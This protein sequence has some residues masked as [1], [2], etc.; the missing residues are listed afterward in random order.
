MKI[1][2]FSDLVCP[3][4]YIGKRRLSIAIEQAG[5]EP[6]LVWRAFQLDPSYPS[7]ITWTLSEA[8][9]NRYGVTA[10]EDRRRQRL[11]TDLAAEVGLEYRLDRA[12]MANTADAHRLVKH[13]HAHGKGT[14]TAEALMRAY[15]IEG[16]D[17]GD[18]ATLDEIAAEQGLPPL[19]PGAYR[20]EVTADLILASRYGIVGVPTIVVDEKHI[21]VSPEIQD[22]TRFLRKHSG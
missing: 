21:L 6:E 2:V 13:G 18:L 15:A 11:V 9:L 16:R 7:G 19:E 17:V 14:E 4:C 5:V 8:H 20:D 3:W 10:E 1:E 12:I 22:L